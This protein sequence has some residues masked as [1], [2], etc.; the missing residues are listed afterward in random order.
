MVEESKRLDLAVRADRAAALIGKIDQ[1]P[2]IDR[3]D[4][5]FPANFR[6]S[7][8]SAVGRAVAYPLARP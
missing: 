2:L 8:P 4:F 1:T 5:Y 7:A 6:P 3:K